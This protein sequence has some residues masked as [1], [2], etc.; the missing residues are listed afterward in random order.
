MC[1][2][3]LSCLFSGSFCVM[4]DVCRDPLLG[5][6]WPMRAEFR[7]GKREESP[8]REEREEE[9]KRRKPRPEA[10]SGRQVNEVAFSLCFERV[11]FQFLFF[12][13]FCSFDCFVAAL[14]PPIVACMCAK[15]TPR[16][17][18]VIS[19]LFSTPL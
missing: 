1:L 11:V 18:R 8:A 16:S 17:S 9:T 13:C 14:G 7:E 12:M 10:I 15:R 3:L 19:F 6:R 4:V 2:T 5:L